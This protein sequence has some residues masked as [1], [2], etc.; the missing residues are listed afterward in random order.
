MGDRFK[1]IFILVIG[2]FQFGMICLNKNVKPWLAPDSMRNG[3]LHTTFELCIY[4]KKQKY[5]VC[6]SR[7]DD[8]QLRS[9]FVIPIIIKSRCSN[10]NL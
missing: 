1:K 10:L 6:S 3:S 8:L 2:Y 4:D 7:Q 5:L 9:Y